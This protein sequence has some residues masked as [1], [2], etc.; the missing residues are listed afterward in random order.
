MKDLSVLQSFSGTTI[1]R[2]IFGKG[3]FSQLA[4]EIAYLGNTPLIVTGGYSFVESPNWE[5]L[6][7]DL[8][9]FGINA[10][11]YRVFE[12]PDVKAIDNAVFEFSGKSIDLIVV[13]GGG[14]ALDV[15]KAL[16]GMLPICGSIANYLEGRE[17]KKLYSGKPLPVIAVPTTAGTG[18]E[19]TKNAV[20]TDYSNSPVKRSFRDHR[21]IPCLALVDPLLIK[22]CPTSVILSNAMDAFTQL[23]ESFLSTR[24]NPFCDALAY[25][26]L[27]RFINNFDPLK[28]HNVD[29]YPSLSYA[30]LIS[31][32]C[33]AQTGL[34]SIHGIA[35]PLGARLKIPHG[36]ACGTTLAA[37]TEVNVIALRERGSSLAALDRYQLVSNIFGL[38]SVD[39]LVE[40]LW[41]WRDNSK[42]VGLT[43]LGLTEELIP[44]IIANSRGN[45]MKTNP[46]ELTDGEIEQILRLSLS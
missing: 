16:A 31:G 6:S 14:S 43:E 39:E 9:N 3:S 37:A 38:D 23:L 5:S 45:S 10:E 22:T 32:I 33:L 1:P 29:A 19:A 15:G 12:E 17:G 44:S 18:S 34:G 24:A 41:K 42:M 2:I 4:K 11:L 46:I 7:A 27:S 30:A 20:I 26:A 21:L 35:A 8:N 25:D 40:T 36:I 28:P 13:I